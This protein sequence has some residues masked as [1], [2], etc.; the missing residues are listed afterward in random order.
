MQIQTLSIVAGSIACNARC[1]FCIAKMTPDG[2]VNNKLPD[3]NVRNFKK[4]LNL[5]EKGNCTTAL[6]T[7]KGEPTLFPSQVSKYLFYIR[8][9]GNIP[10]VEMQTNGIKLL[11]ENYNEHLETWYDAGL[12]TIALSISGVNANLNQR[13]YTPYKKEYIDLEKLVEKLHNFGFSIRLTTT[14]LG[15]NLVPDLVSHVEDVIS[16]A[17]RT[18]CEQIKLTPVTKPNEN[19]SGQEDQWVIQNGVGKYE[20]KQLQLHIE[21][22]A[23]LLR[24]L[25]WGG[26]VYDYKGQNVAYYPCLTRNENATDEIRSLIFFPDGHVRTDWAYEGSILF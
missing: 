1:P 9:W 20:L 18:G 2:G 22:N 16:F 5:A 6:I 23:T 11:E 3:I 10:I 26:N 15:R 4:V 13:I 17:K 25:M 24:K 19:D 7:S 8:E 12:N 14:L 21:Q